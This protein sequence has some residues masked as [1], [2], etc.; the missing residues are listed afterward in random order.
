MKLHS[1]LPI[2]ILA[3]ITAG[4]CAK[5]NSQKQAEVPFCGLLSTPGAFD[6]KK[7]LTRAIMSAGYHSVFAHDSKC[8]STQGNDLSTEIAIS[9]S[10]TPKNL[11][12]KLSH[13]LKHHKNTDVVFEGV[14]SG[15]GGPYGADAARFR[16]VVD[17]LISVRGATDG[18][19]HQ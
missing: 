7:V 15:K 18:A 9:D 19:D 8:Q 17:K 5:M 4:S 1:I 10:V 14:F 13:Y 12:K 16:F 6:Q 3:H 2:M 11:Q